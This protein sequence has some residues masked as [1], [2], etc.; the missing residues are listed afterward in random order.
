MKC[1]KCGTEFDSKCCPEC[2]FNTAQSNQQSD[3]SSTWN[4][5]A[6]AP[7]Q[8]PKKMAALL[9]LGLLQQ[10]LLLWP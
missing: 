7:Q 3:T 9:Q 2:G 8:S 5:V 1:P 10:F 6:P 4:Q